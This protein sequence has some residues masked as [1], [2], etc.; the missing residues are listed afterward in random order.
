MSICPPF[1]TV[2]DPHSDDAENTLPLSTRARAALL[3]RL[4]A[5]IDEEE[6]LIAEIERK[7]AATLGGATAPWA[8]AETGTAPGGPVHGAAMKEPLAAA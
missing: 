6:R 2:C 5:W 1:R 3:N 8:R 4:E 7:I